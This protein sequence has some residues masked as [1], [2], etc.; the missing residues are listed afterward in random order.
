MIRSAQERLLPFGLDRPEQPPS[1]SWRRETQEVCADEAAVMAPVRRCYRCSGRALR[2]RLL[3]AV[4]AA[5]WVGRWMVLM[6]Q[7]QV[8]DQC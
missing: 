7:R 5:E 3:L 8:G 6:Q 1:L 2:S 4:V